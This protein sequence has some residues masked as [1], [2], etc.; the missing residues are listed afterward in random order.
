MK[1]LG[2]SI[3]LAAILVLALTGG[4]A[5]KA[6]GGNTTITATLTGYQETPLTLASP[7]S[8]QFNGTVSED[9]T[10]I[11]F[12]LSYADFPTNVLV[13]HIHLGAPAITGGV[14]VF[15]C[16]GGGRPAC[17]SPS[18][19]VTGTITAENVGAIPAQDLAA[20]DLPKLLEAMAAGATYVNV[21]T[22]AHGGGEIRG[23]VQVIDA[24]QQNN[25]GR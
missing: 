14:T 22:T 18:G 7:A 3:A 10:S 11:D 8:G 24:E 15:L 12:E 19:T 4:P 16:G 13:A 25:K 20:G 9:G 21:H 1:K 17:P 6:G 2:I 23:L 5:T